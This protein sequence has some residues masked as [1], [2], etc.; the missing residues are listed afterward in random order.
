MEAILVIV[1]V[2]LLV[3]VV[4][5]L[6]LL[7]GTIVKN[8]PSATPNTLLWTLATVATGVIPGIIAALLYR[9]K[10]MSPGSAF[11]LG[12]VGYLAFAWLIVGILWFLGF[13]V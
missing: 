6:A 8:K 12:I 5:W 10:N 7:P 4:I 9:Y 11:G 1:G 2:I 13:D 3:G